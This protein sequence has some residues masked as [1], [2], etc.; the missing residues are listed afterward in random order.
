M[1]SSF[2]KY[3]CIPLLSVCFLG[4]IAGKGFALPSALQPSTLLDFSSGIGL[5]SGSVSNGHEIFHFEA[6][7]GQTAYINLEVTAVHD[8]FFNDDALAFSC[9][10]CKGSF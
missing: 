9:L 1:K 10:V 7:A 5:A 2:L 4:G 8:S 3:I 6:E